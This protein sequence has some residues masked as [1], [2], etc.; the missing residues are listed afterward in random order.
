[1]NLALSGLPA[2]KCH[3]DDPR[4]HGTTIHLLPDEGDVIQSFRE[5][6]RDAAAGKLPISPC[7]EM[8]IHTARD[9]LLRDKEGR[10]SA[11]LFVQWVPYKLAESSWEVETEGY[12]RHLLS[13]C[14]RFAPGGSGYRHACNSG[15]KGAQRVVKSL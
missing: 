13:I 11:A 6:Y 1:M 15:A 2:F 9:P 14:D 5:A 3:P 8:Y 7:I 10:H 12:V 4:I